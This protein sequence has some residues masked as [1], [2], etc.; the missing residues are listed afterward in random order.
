MSCG[1]WQPRFVI[2]VVEFLNL[3][4][5]QSTHQYLSINHSL[6]SST[7]HATAIKSCLHVKIYCG[8]SLQ[9]HVQN[10][11]VVCT[12]FTSQVGNRR[13]S[14]ASP[15]YFLS[16]WRTPASTSAKARLYLVLLFHVPIEGSSFH[17]I[18]V[19]NSPVSFIFNILRKWDPL[20]IKL[21]I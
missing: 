14:F 6:P 13:N 16:N 1:S 3:Q 15:K 4:S 21:F 2:L 8:R 11:C 12:I 5:Y 20:K 17:G 10:Y 18:P 9:Q 19:A 7:H